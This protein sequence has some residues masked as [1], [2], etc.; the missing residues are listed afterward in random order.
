MCSRNS[1]C[2]SSKPLR[3]HCSSGL[4]GGDKAD[5]ALL[6]KANQVV[7]KGEQSGA[8]LTTLSHLG[9]NTRAEVAVLAG[10]SRIRVSSAKGCYSE[11]APSEGDVS[12]ATLAAFLKV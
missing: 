7:R 3:S 6:A 2:S 1:N 5:I 10:V 11:Y 8:T 9:I 12:N 4:Y